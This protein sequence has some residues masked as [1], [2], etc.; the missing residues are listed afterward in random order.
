MALIC[1]EDGRGS[2]LFGVARCLEQGPAERA[3]EILSTVSVVAAAGFGLMALL[4][5]YKDEDGR[6]TA[7]GRLA[8]FGVVL[9]ALI[10]LAL[11][12]LTSDIDSAKAASARKLA[13]IQGRKQQSDYNRQ[14]A[15]FAGIGRRQDQALSQGE[16]V[17]RSM[18]LSLAGQRDQI[19]LS[20]GVSRDLAQTARASQASSDALMRSVWEGANQISAR[21]LAVEAEVT[22]VFHRADPPYA[23]LLAQPE[24]AAA[25]SVFEPDARLVVA[26][27]DRATLNLAAPLTL[28]ANDRL[29]CPVYFSRNR[30]CGTD[31]ALLAAS[32]A[33]QRTVSRPSARHV[34]DRMPGER[35]EVRQVAEFTGFVGDRRALLRKPD[36][37]GRVIQL[38]LNVDN[39]SAL[40]PLSFQHAP[41]AFHYPPDRL[42]QLGYGLRFSQF[43]FPDDM[44]VQ[45]SPPSERLLPC[46]VDL[47]VKLGDRQMAA[48]RGQLYGYGFY[49]ETTGKGIGLIVPPLAVPPDLFPDYQAPR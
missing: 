23:K 4:T 1:A 11:N 6:T 35:I 30:T 25:L 14:L 38:A 28:V 34:V 19:R 33:S 37:N 15:E 29:D 10:S 32:T 12:A 7:Y 44:S 8:A 36:W 26:V 40:T 46:V 47:R 24:T 18:A 3:V 45:Y 13:D 41:D 49:N 31:Q 20:Q 17:S 22:C 2:W 16:K 48:A 5:D 21:D 43:Y 42:H 9:S 39:A 27:S